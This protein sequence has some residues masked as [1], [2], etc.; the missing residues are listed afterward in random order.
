MI[1]QLAANR[2]A[3]YDY[4]ILETYEAGI[5]LKGTEVKSIRAGKANLRDSFGRFDKG[6]LFVFNMHI[7]PYDY[8]NIY[9]VAPLRTRKLLLHKEE[10]KRLIGKV[11]QKGLTLV[12]TKL[13]AKD[14]RIKLELALVRGKKQYDKREQI[15]KRDLDRESR[16]KM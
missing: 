14:N 2:K 8:G 6:E 10:I 16:H 9:N 4:E 7:T 15:K 3:F 12:V 11:T 13:Y 5:V 1:K